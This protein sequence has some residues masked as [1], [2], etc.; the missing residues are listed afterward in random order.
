M[1]NKNSIKQGHIKQELM[2]YEQV[3]NEITKK[4]GNNRTKK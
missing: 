1:E 2:N 3:G 4:I